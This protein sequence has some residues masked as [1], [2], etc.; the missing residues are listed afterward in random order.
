MKYENLSEGDTVYAGIL[1]KDVETK[2]R[3][4]KVTM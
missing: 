1:L 3:D 4:F 2:I